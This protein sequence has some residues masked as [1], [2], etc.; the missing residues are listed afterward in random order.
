MALRIL[1]L[2]GV[3]RPEVEHRFHESRRWRFDFAW[4]DHLIALEVEG[5]TWNNGRHTRGKAFEGDC[6]KYNAA[7]I[8]GW[9]VFRVTTDMV[10]DGRASRVVEEAF[11]TRSR[12]SGQR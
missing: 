2:H 3:P 11:L 4:P 1:G 10:Y 12:T 7:A 8:L 6:E 9:R 5:G